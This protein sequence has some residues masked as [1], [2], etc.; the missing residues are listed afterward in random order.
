M[1]AKA[2][3]L[4]ALYALLVLI[5]RVITALIIIVMCPVFVLFNLIWGGKKT[6]VFMEY[7]GDILKKKSL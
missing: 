2:W 4:L 3:S 7:L 1:Q 5:A 6:G